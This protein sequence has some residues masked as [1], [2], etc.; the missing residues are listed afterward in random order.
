MSQATLE[1]AAAFDFFTLRVTTKFVGNLFAI[2]A[3]INSNYA[4]FILSPIKLTVLKHGFSWRKITIRK[5]QL[6]FTVLYDVHVLRTESAY[7]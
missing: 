3:I 5:F 7:V 2:F 6:Q 4:Y 1:C